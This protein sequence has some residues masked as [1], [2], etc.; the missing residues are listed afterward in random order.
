MLATAEDSGRGSIGFL[1]LS[2]RQGHRPGEAQMT[3]RSPFKR[4]AVVAALFCAAD[5]SCT[6]FAE[7]SVGEPGRGAGGKNPLKNVYFGEQHLHTANSADAFSWGTRN[8]P[9][10]AYRFCKGEAIKKITSGKMIQKKTPYDWCAITDHTEYARGVTQ[11][12]P[13]QLSQLLSH[14]AHITLTGDGYTGASARSATRPGSGHRVSG[15]RRPA[16]AL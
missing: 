2:S 3:T 8:G 13:V 5:L 7:D 14:L 4:Q 12:D 11:A 9:N 6:A 10:E 1:S 15:C 16:A